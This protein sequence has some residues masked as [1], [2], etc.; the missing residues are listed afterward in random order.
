MRGKKKKELVAGIKPCQ[1]KLYEG[2]GY[3][4]TLPYQMGTAHFFSAKAT[5]MKELNVQR[6][7]CEAQKKSKDVNSFKC[8]IKALLKVG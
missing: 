1:V 8:R 5:G 7:M 4:F 2:L 6:Q 3:P